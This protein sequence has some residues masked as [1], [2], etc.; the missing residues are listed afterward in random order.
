[1][2]QEKGQRVATATTT[3]T[4]GTGHTVKEDLM[5]NADHTVSTGVPV[6]AESAA[7][8]EN[9]SLMAKEDPS[10]KVENTGHTTAENAVHIMEENASLTVKEDLSEKVAS[11]GRTTVVSASL[12]VREG[13]SEKAV[14]ED[15]SMLAD[16][17][18][19][20]GLQEAAA[21]TESLREDSAEDM[22][23]SST[24]HPRP[25]STR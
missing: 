10:G 15:L 19:T 12:T 5:A 2:A 14:R 18:H 6:R 21:A 3:M 13:P 11:A 1:M 20:A 22:S 4:G 23:H 24:R 17:S 7:A 25:A 8:M 9:T 16:A